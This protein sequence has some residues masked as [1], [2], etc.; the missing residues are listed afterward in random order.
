MTTG[1]VKSLQNVWGDGGNLLARGRE[2]VGS[3]KMGTMAAQI[4]ALTAVANQE[5]LCRSPNLGI[6][7]KMAGDVRRR[8]FIWEIP[9]QRKWCE[10]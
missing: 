1:S 8:T 9:V 7:Y 3:V 2:T 10:Q 6:L 4:V 5:S